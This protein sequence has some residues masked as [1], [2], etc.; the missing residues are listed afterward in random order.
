MG[1]TQ[2]SAPGAPCG[3]RQNTM[4]L[5]SSDQSSA[6]SCMPEGVS[7]GN[8]SSVLTEWKNILKGPNREDEKT[9]CVPSGDHMGLTSAEA[10]K[11]SLSEMPRPRLMTQT[12]LLP[13]I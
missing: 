7:E 6:M 10:S 13:S 8:G 2:I 9:I 3:Y 4:Y 5:P 12:S 1:L 11:V